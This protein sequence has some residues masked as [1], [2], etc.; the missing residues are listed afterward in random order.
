MPLEAAT[1]G[2]ATARLDAVRRWRDRPVVVVGDVLLDQWR[3]TEPRRLCRE[4]PAPVVAVLGRADCPGGAGNTAVNLAALGARPVLVAPV[5]DDEN[6]QCLRARLGPAGLADALVTIPGYRTQRRRRIVSADQLLLCEEDG[7]EVPV[8]RGGPVLTRLRRVLSRPGPEPVLLIC[9]YA[10]GAID[11]RTRDWI[12]ARRAAFGFV[13]V[14]ARDLSRWAGLAPT[15]VTPSDAET[16]ALL[17]VP[18]TGGSDDER[19]EAAAGRV[20]DVLRVT[21][22]EV[23]A[24]TLDVAGT[25]AAAVDGPPLRTPTRS[26]PG[27]HAVGAG[28]VYFATMALALATGSD[29]AVAADLAGRAAALTVDGAGTCV[30]SRSALLASLPPDGGHPVDGAVD[31]AT[32]GEIVAR[33][34]ARGSCVVFTN[35]CFDVLHRGHVGYLAQARRLGDVLIVAVNSDASVRR[36]KG[37]QRPINTAEDRVAVVSALSCVDHVVVFDEDSPAGLIEAVRPDLYVKGGDY[38]PELVPEA[39]LV[40]RLGGQV[41]TLDFIPDRSTS[42]IIDRIRST[43]RARQPQP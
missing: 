37:S 5:G 40:R 23:A 9:D 34:R 28:D 38:P 25:V 35:G 11:D 6:G 36:L 17:G 18:R 41:R 10:A 15:L 20:P 2:H 33:H 8:P 3:F 42:A 14:D 19:A 24:V 27:C 4:G 43:G 39:P 16:A 22:A 30:C 29:T 12:I 32:L 26:A 13:G 7:E 1:V 31:A 21:G